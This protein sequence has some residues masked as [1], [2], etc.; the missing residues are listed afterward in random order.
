MKNVDFKSILAMLTRGQH[1]DLESMKPVHIPYSLP[2][3]GKVRKTHTA[4]RYKPFF[5]TG[6]RGFPKSFIPIGVIPAPTLDQVRW[7]ERE[8]K[9][10]LQVKLGKMFHKHSGK[11]FS[12]READFN[13]REDE[14]ILALMNT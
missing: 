6:F 8:Y 5:T 3:A 11:S 10:K 1:P 4:P 13:K 2:G 12:V 7:Y 14:R 9:V